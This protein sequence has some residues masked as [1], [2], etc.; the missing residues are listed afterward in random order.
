MTKKEFGRCI[1][2][3][4]VV[5]LTLCL[6]C[7]LFELDNNTN[8]D[9]RFYTYRNLNEDTI[10][11]V[12][13]GT[14]GADRYW[15]ASKAYEEYGM[16]V[17]PL[18]ADAMPTW[19][20]VNMIEEAYTYQNPELIIIDVRAYGQDNTKAST[21]DVRARRILDAMSLFSLT[22]LKAAFT[23]MKTIH[24]AFPEEECFDLSYLLSY[25]KYHSKW[26]D[27][28]YSFS[29]NLGSKEHTYAG[30]FMNKKLSL[31]ATEQEWKPYNTEILEPLDPVAEKSLYELLEYIKAKDLNVLFVDTPQFKDETEMGRA[32]TVYKILDEYGMN[33]E[34]Y[35]LTDA[36]GVFL[37]Y[38]HLNPKADFYDDGHVNFQGAD[39]FTATFAKYLNENYDLPD[40]R[41]DPNVSESWEGIY[42][43]TQKRIKNWAE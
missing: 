28:D 16:T 41:N 9:M 19:L 30:L 36:Q 12:W 1:A 24:E 26:T 23:T 17:Y 42:A 32:N 6:L 22:R 20:F 8:K 13:I 39:K 15:V 5:C 43:K 3:I 38:G 7:D 21:M 40:R 37:E 27:E 29:K 2:F 10:D 14:S 34:N 18:V 31:Q 11:A 25:I 4:L 33:Y 35:C